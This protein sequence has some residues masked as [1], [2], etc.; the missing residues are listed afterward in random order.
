MS[1]TVHQHPEH[2]SAVVDVHLREDSWH[3]HYRFSTHGLM[4]EEISAKHAAIVEHHRAKS[5][6]HDGFN[7]LN[8][9]VAMPGAG[10]FHIRALA[11]DERGTDVRM[12]LRVTAPDGSTLNL[13]RIAPGVGDLPSDAEIRSIVRDAAVAWLNRE[14]ASRGHVESV[15]AVLELQ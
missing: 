1:A 15:K 8:R 5:E 11:I 3:G 4:A 9:I 2:R 6:R 14:T 10:D 7:R 13:D 12:I